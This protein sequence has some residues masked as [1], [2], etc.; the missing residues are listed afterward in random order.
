MK[1]ASRDI[2]INQ[3]IRGL[4]LSPAVNPAY[5]VYYFR[6][7]SLIGDGTIVKSITNATLE[8]VQILLPPMDVQNRIVS[9]L[10]KLANLELEI[11]SELEARKKQYAY[12]RNKLLTFG[13]L[14]IA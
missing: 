6:T 2:A 10:D 13:E 8:K 12:Y 1:I 3:D 5:L 9:A 14:L 7:F 11:E 4:T